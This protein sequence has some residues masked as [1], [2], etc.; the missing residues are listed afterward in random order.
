LAEAGA[1][2]DSGG[3]S[4]SVDY[5]GPASV[6]EVLASLTVTAEPDTDGA[7]SR[8]FDE[9]SAPGREQMKVAVPD[10]FWDAP[11]VDIVRKNDPVPAAQLPSGYVHWLGGLNDVV[12]T[13]LAGLEPHI[14]NDPEVP[15]LLYARVAELYGRSPVAAAKDIPIQVVHDGNVV[16]T[17]RVGLTPHRD[18]ARMLGGWR[19][20][21]RLEEQKYSFDAAAGIFGRIRE[22]EGN[23]MLGTRYGLRGGVFRT[24]ATQFFAGLQTIRVI[25]NRWT[26]HSH[27]YLMPVSYTVSVQPVGQDAVSPEVLDG[28]M[29]ARYRETDAYDYGLPVP[30]DALVNG[31]LRGLPKPA[32][33]GE[34]REL[35]TDASGLVFGHAA[36]RNMRV[37]QASEQPAARYDGMA[38]A[39]AEVFAVLAD[40]GLVPSTQDGDSAPEAYLLDNATVVRERLS[41]AWLEPRYDQLTQDGVTLWLMQLQP[42]MAQPTP[43]RVTL[44]LV[45]R[46]VADP[47]YTPPYLGVT[48]AQAQAHI[49]TAQD[50]IGTRQS[51]T[52]RVSGGAFAWL[53]GG[54]GKAAT[55]TT[56]SGEIVAVSAMSQSKTGAASAVWDV[57]HDLRVSLQDK[58]SERLVYARR[59]DSELWLDESLL[60]GMS[61]RQPVQVTEGG[62]HRDLFAD[63]ETVITGVNVKGSVLAARAALSNVLG[64]SASDIAAPFDPDGPSYR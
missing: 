61:G 33:P 35:P 54:G 44:L 39:R 25:N 50:N 58:H 10:A 46:N 13:A 9:N 63:A 19:K 23:A 51:R 2:L 59:V 12:H 8:T 1:K 56:E 48:E 14:G 24:V 4:V 40:R 7:A 62:T 36:A 16:A 21:L 17:V 41:A 57:A 34:Q 26:G 55:S 6:V 42:G 18:G 60:P 28:S 11:Q 64:R 37:V 38:A 29:V 20:G 53:T 45:P 22:I 3:R 32:H 49:T 31:Q 43:V 15:R 5:R 30:A 47:A 27:N 52:G